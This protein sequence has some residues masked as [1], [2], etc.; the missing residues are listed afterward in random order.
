MK[1][2]KN[3]FFALITV[4][5][6]ACS[7]D[8]FVGNH[9]N[10]KQIELQVAIKGTAIGQVKSIVHPLTGETLEPTCFLLELLDPVTKKVIGTLQDCIVDNVVPGDGAITSRLMTSMNLEGRGSILAES[11]VQRIIQPPVEEFYFST[12]FT[13][14]ENNVIETTGEFDGMLG[15]ISLKG[16]V[17]MAN[18]D[19]RI[20]TFNNNYTVNLESY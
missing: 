16:E 5:F 10:D 4:L 9:P 13:P 6:V 8:D 20:M 3:I 2:I 7:D 14:K 1:I 19:Q 18:M 17:N 12:H 15:K 11:I